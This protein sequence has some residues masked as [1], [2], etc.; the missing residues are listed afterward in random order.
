MYKQVRKPDQMKPPRQAGKK[1]AQQ[2]ARPASKPATP[3]AEK[4]DWQ[5][6]GAD[7][8]ANWEEFE[9]GGRGVTRAPQ[10][11]GRSLLER[12]TV[13]LYAFGTTKAALPTSAAPAPT[14]QS[15][16]P[17]AQV[18][19][20]FEDYANVPEQAIL[21]T[22]EPAQST[23]AM[24]PT[25]PQDRYRSNAWG[26]KF[27]YGA[28]STL[29]SSY[30]LGTEFRN[31]IVDVADPDVPLETLKEDLNTIINTYD[32]ID[33][34]ERNRIVELVS[35]HK[36]PTIFDEYRSGLTSY[37]QNA[38]FISAMSEHPE[39]M[40]I[41]NIIDN[42]QF[43][44]GNFQYN[45]HR[46]LYNNAFLIPQ[47]SLAA[48]V[49]AYIA[50]IRSV[51]FDVLETH[52]LVNV[53]IHDLVTNRLDGSF[54]KPA[55][56]VEQEQ[57]RDLNAVNIGVLDP[58]AETPQVTESGLRG[59]M[60]TEFVLQRV[61][62]L[63]PEIT[64]Y[65]DARNFSPVSMVSILKNN[66]NMVNNVVV[67]I[68]PFTMPG[69]VYDFLETYAQR[70]DISYE[71]AQREVASVNMNVLLAMGG[72]P[73]QANEAT[74]L[75]NAVSG[76][77]FGDMA[78]LRPNLPY[79][80]GSNLNLNQI[81][82]TPIFDAQQLAWIEARTWA[83]LQWC[84]GFYSIA[85][86][87][88]FQ[89]NLTPSLARLAADQTPQNLAEFQNM[90]QGERLNAAVLDNFNAIYSMIMAKEINVHIQ[91][92]QGKSVHASEELGKTAFGFSDRY[93]DFS[94]AKRTDSGAVDTDT[95]N[96]FLYK[97]DGTVYQKNDYAAKKMRSS[98]AVTEK[99]AE[100]KNLGLNPQYATT[101]MPTDLRATAMGLP[102]SSGLPADMIYRASGIVKESATP[103][104]IAGYSP[105][106]WTKRL[107]GDAYNIDPQ[108]FDSDFNRLRT[109]V[110][111]LRQLNLAS[112]SL[113]LASN[114]RSGVIM[115]A[116][117]LKL[118]KESLP[119]MVSNIDPGLISAMRKKIN[120]EEAHVADDIQRYSTQFTSK[121]GVS[122]ANYI[123]YETD[124][125]FPVAPPM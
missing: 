27:K 30:V 20:I 54:D 38:K 102:G 77:E 64:A 29:L 5:I 48:I 82:G 12:L 63:M 42:G 14:V 18:S 1:S 95:I 47:N 3:P 21:P 24:Q 76:L 66:P 80:N 67:K 65:I 70:Y 74:K 96:D 120:A 86:V 39:L 60:R 6:S 84:L 40:P 104:D 91:N 41:D 8:R 117:V 79:A 90:P 121:Y 71:Q 32:K 26:G 23:P 116:E 73:G 111:R 78:A 83:T 61:A 11:R 19:T 106:E 49:N 37:E 57:Y 52:D 75:S 35:Q 114:D 36:T 33:L 15:G 9:A 62:A 34:A 53:V 115:D 13:L 125:T 119:V 123:F 109:L 4:E 51:E 25:P 85:N 103:S 44:S 2:N 55:K 110:Q 105:P 28:F 118:L 98:T 87:L 58:T 7:L 69:G 113:Q 81:E 10:L 108:S 56:Y 43:I 31:F 68:Y 124:P 101:D 16:N 88:V 99:I 72:V 46:G 112:A 50:G 94:F 45:A 89:Q 92:R 97:M 107:F 100:F 22:T 122:F 59:L 17:L 93:P